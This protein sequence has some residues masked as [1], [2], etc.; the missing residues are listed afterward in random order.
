MSNYEIERVKLQ[1]EGSRKLSYDELIKI[2]KKIK[3]D[4]EHGIVKVMYLQKH[5]GGGLGDE[6]YK[7]RYERPSNEIPTGAA[8]E[9]CEK[10]GIEGKKIFHDNYCQLPKIEYLMSTIGLFRKEFIDTDVKRSKTDPEYEGLR[11]RWK[12]GTLTQEDIKVLQ[13]SVTQKNKKIK[14]KNENALT[15]I[16]YREVK[17]LS[18]TDVVKIPGDWPTAI[19]LYYVNKKGEKSQFRVDGKGNIVI[20]HLP[21]KDYQDET[22]VKSLIKKITDI[23]PDWKTKNKN[24]KILDLTYIGYI[25]KNGII[26]IETLKKDMFPKNEKYQY[27]NSPPHLKAEYPVEGKKSVLTLLGTKSFEMKLSESPKLSEPGQITL[28]PQSEGINYTTTIFRNGYFRINVSSIDKKDKARITENKTKNIGNHIRDIIKKLIVEKNSD[29]TKKTKILTTISGKSL[30]N[31]KDSKTNVCRGVQKDKAPPQ[32]IPYSFKGKCPEP[33]Q[34]VFPLEGIEGKDEL[35]YPCCGKLTKTGKKSETEYR[36]KLIEGFPTKNTQNHAWRNVPDNLDETD[37]LSGVL[38]KDFDKTGTKLKAK[39][40]GKGPEYQDV[41]MVNSNLRN[42]KFIVSM[43]NSEQFFIERTDI[44]PESRHVVGLREIFKQR[45]KLFKAKYGPIEGKK[46]FSEYITAFHQNLGKIDPRSETSTTLNIDL[47]KERFFYYLTHIELQKLYTK[48]YKVMSVPHKANIVAIYKTGQ[49]KDEVAI[50]DLENHTTEIVTNWKK[51]KGTLVGHR[52]L[53]NKK[54]N[55][56]PWKHVSEE[57]SEG[58]PPPNWIVVDPN[59]LLKDDIIKFCDKTDLTKNTLVFV[60]PNKNKKALVWYD[61][62]HDS[63]PHM[64]VQLVGNPVESNKQNTTWNV[65]INN[66]ILDKKRLAKRKNLTIKIKNSENKIVNNLDPKDRYFW[67]KPRYNAKGLLDIR[68]PLSL[69]S[70]SPDKRPSE[71]EFFNIIEQTINKIPAKSIKPV[72]FK[73]S[74]SWH[75]DSKRVIFDNKLKVID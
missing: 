36:K 15:T 19:C 61:K 8:C 16:K 34:V 45:K 7:V 12:S 3:L 6:K 50:F 65:G 56:V 5:E 55:F 64:V 59:D 41:K 11:K 24:P 70:H 40:P 57:T 20:L 18:G 21:W 29:N 58:T 39:I 22:P 67:V 27:L 75:I 73:G 53:K 68:N 28:R 47:L 46:K 31:R 37:T 49:K 13:D 1:F 51:F 62:P 60:S 48:K 10:V 17:P 38:P 23:I 14:I 43:G 33:G 66:S 54:Q 26:D 9:H 30:P 32:P 69:I 42:G 74:I 71:T 72:A 35:W 44:Q 25:I 52:Y 2:S 63:K 4:K